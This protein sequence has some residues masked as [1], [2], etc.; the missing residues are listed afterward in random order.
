MDNKASTGSSDP[1]TYEIIGA[2]IEVHRI[3]GPGMME[4]LYEEAL[5]IELEERGLAFERQKRII[6]NYKGH[7]IGKSFADVVVENRVV[8]EL[9]SV[10]AL[11][12]V[13]EAQLISYLR[14]AKVHVGLL[15]NFNVATL[16]KGV[17]RLVV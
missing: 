15:I 2:A 11:A 10:S 3:L 4:S 16:K 13:H 17:K 12:P 1:L 5:C 14:L 9:K 8:L 6:A 7:E